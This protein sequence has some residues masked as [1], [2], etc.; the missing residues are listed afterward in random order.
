M[1]ALGAVT[2]I[3]FSWYSDEAVLRL[4]QQ[5]IFA[6]S[7]QYVGR[8][9]QVARAGIVLHGLRRPRAGRGRPRP[10]LRSCARF[11]TSAVI[12]DPLL[13]E[14]EGRRE[15]LQCPYHAWTYDLDGSLRA[16]PAPTASPDSTAPSS[17]C[18]R[19]RSAPGGRSSSSTPIRTRHRSTETLG[20]LPAILA[21]GGID[22]DAL[23]FDARAEADEYDANWKV[24]VENFLECYH[25]AVAHPSLAK[26]IDVSADAYRLETRPTFSSQIAAPR[27][28][29]GGVYDATGEIEAGQFHLLFPNT[30]DQ[31]DARSHEP[32]DRTGLPRGAGTRVPLSW[33]T[34][35]GRT[36]TR[37]EERVSRARH[38]GRRRGP[39]ARR[40]RPRGDALGAVEHGRL[41]PESEQ[42]I[43]H[44]Q[45]LLVDAL[46]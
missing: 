2:T 9:G 39:G 29:G 42:L 26:A 8:V 23:V 28:G 21:D 30:V 15:T 12:A 11:S 18:D 40:A 19:R 37:L 24:C 34:S 3:P 36:W 22:V 17:G 46:G 35:S 20:E 1:A 27:N 16:A 38:A 4:E 32:V 45:T 44:F 25:C 31:R 33:T 43:A 7:W 5:R 41:L 13:C 10:R 14:G 6:S